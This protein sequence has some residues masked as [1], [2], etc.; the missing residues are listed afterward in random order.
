MKL[1]EYLVESLPVPEMSY[2]DMLIIAIKREEKSAKLYSRLPA[3][4]SDQALRGIF[5]KLVSEEK[6]HR[7]Y[8]EAVY[9]KDIQADNLLP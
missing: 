8:F 2:Q 9:G 5:K 4:T 6:K 1:N 3:C 7:D